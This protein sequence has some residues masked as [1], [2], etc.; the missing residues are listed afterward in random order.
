MCKLTRPAV[1]R[2][3]VLAMASLLSA[4]G[5]AQ[6]SEVPIFSFDW[7]NGAGPA[8]ALAFGP[9]GVLY[10]TANEGGGTPGA[11]ACYHRHA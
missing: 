11:F 4:S 5:R 10:G 2:L 1:A 8:S 6:V 7:V 9:D 3:A